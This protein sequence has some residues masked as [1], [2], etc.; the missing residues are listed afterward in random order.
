M[1][2]KITHAINRTAEEHSS[3]SITRQETKPS[4]TPDFFLLDEEGPFR[5]YSIGNEISPP[6]WRYPTHFKEARY[7]L[8]LTA[9]ERLETEQIQLFSDSRIHIRLAPAL[10]E[11]STDGLTCG[12]SFLDSQN[13]AKFNIGVFELLTDNAPASWR[14][15][16]FDIAWLA[17]RAGKFIIECGPGA[18]GDPT[19]D[20]LALADFCVARE[21]DLKVLLART[22][23]AIRIKNEIAHFSAAYRNDFYARTQDRQSQEAAG[24]KRNVRRLQVIS[25]QENTT[26]EITIPDLPPKAGEGAYLYAT[27]L[28]KR[29]I[30]EAQPDYKE[31][32]LQRVA[33]QGKVKILSICS[34]AARTEAALAAAVP[35]GVEWSLLDINEDLLQMASKQF[36]PQTPL[37]LI[38]ADA[39][40]LVVTD[41]QWDIII[42]VSALHHLVELEKVMCF[43]SSSLK[44]DGE[45]WSI[46]EAVGRNGNRL[47]PE[48]AIAA[49]AVFSA[50]PAR[51]RLNSASQLTDDTIPDNDHSVGCF[52][53][54][55]SEEILSLL[56]RWLMPVQVHRRNCFLWRMINQ[57]YCDNFNLEDPEDRKLIMAMVRAEVRHFRNGGRGAELLGVYGLRHD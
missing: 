46:G 8:V 33:A 45:F 10:P 6:R 1:L 57:A 40:N 26:E 28:L 53:G 15:M 11:L 35:A 2:S 44:A 39:N 56:D 7:S 23:Q 13:N 36:S 24:I 30:K 3:A 41:E 5:T 14:V 21:T 12:I 55:R 29:T 22:H 51:Y 17:D 4:S 34:G 20:W 18:G 31:R 50:L 47:W 25:H 37:D 16:E 49:N 52:E 19:A 42:C 9:W 32:L 48:A 54:I 43:I 27:R 38:V